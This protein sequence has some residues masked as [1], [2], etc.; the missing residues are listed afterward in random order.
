M[1]D[2]VNVTP[3]ELNRLANTLTSALNGLR[4]N[5]GAIPGEVDAGVSTG[6]VTQTIATF[7][8]SIARM[9]A[10]TEH[11]AGEVTN[12]GGGYTRSDDQAAAELP[13]LPLTPDD[14]AGGT[15]T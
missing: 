12:A 10:D 8:E 14:T 1:G 15:L 3:E 11:Q 4:D 13:P 7:Y 6:P 5:S 9:A 2:H